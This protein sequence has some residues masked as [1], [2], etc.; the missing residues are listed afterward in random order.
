[1]HQ[2]IDVNNGFKLQIHRNMLIL[3]DDQR[4]EITELYARATQKGKFIPFFESF[5]ENVEHGIHGQQHARDILVDFGL[6]L[7]CREA[8]ESRWSCRWSTKWQLEGKIKSERQRSLY[9]W[10]ITT[11]MYRISKIN[12]ILSI[13]GYDHREGQKKDNRQLEKD[14]GRS[15]S[16]AE[17]DRRAPY[18][19]TGCLA[20]LEISEDLTTGQILRIS[21]IQKHNEACKGSAMKRRPHVPLHSHV[22]EVALQQLRAG[23][24]YLI[25]FLI[26]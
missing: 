12:K 6:D 19:F 2:M 21:G 3:T 22:Y 7:D 20:H 24:R 18:D 13:C 23:A 9:Q 17:W 26:N 11:F 5:Y 8:L 16:K 14:P 10:Y 25:C 4:N 1:M 15:P